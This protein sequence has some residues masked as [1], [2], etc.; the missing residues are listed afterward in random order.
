MDNINIRVEGRYGSLTDFEWP[1]VP[2]FAVI[3]GVN[4]TGKSQLLEII[5]RSHG[6]SLGNDVY[7]GPESE[8]PARCLIDGASFGYGEVFHSYGEWTQLRGGTATQ[9]G[10]EQSL[11][12]LYDNRVSYPRSSEGTQSGPLY[13]PISHAV[14]ESAGVTVAEATQLSPDDFVRH[15]T[16]GLF[17]AHAWGAGPLGSQSLALLFLAYLLFERDAKALG[18]TDEEIR[19][20]CGEQP[21]WILLNEILD[22]S[23]LPFRVDE[24]QAIRPTAML[25]SNRVELRLRDIER[26]EEVPFHRLSS[27]EKVIM[28]TVLWQYG[29][30]LT[31]RHHKL[32]LLDEPDAHLHPSLTRRFLEVI[33]KVF[34]EERGVRVIMTTHSPSTV[35]LVPKEDL[36]EMRRTGQRIQAVQSKDRVI[37]TLTDGFVV[38]QDATRIVLVEGR[39][40]PPFYKLVWDL[41]T[42]RDGISDPG[43]LEPFPALAFIHGKGVETVQELLPQMRDRGLQNFHGIIDKDLGNTPATGVHALERYSI[44]NYLFDPIN[45]W[46]LLCS[47]GKAPSVPGVEVGRGQVAFARNLA[48]DKLQKIADAVL[49]KVEGVLTDLNGDD[50]V[51]EEVRFVNSRSVR[52]PRWFLHHRGKNIVRSFQQAFNQL[53]RLKP[54]DLLANYESVNMVPQ[55]LMK[56]LREIQASDNL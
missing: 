27:G 21:P 15:L 13:H 50:K 10:F 24:P 28:S 17:W 42:R 34:V 44:E 53:W 20:R 33:R 14:A 54:E 22:A 37:A 40:D 5:A 19:R 18:E 43:P 29:A 51:V 16:L 30:Q 55:E 49:A 25:S 48:N 47:E 36:F 8:M 31:G 32:L 46:L 2:P 6:V 39:D 1:D 41:L 56:L 3:T 26:N 45:V 35:A 52:Y 7:V 9:E 38:V 23:G 12:G 4:G 11:R